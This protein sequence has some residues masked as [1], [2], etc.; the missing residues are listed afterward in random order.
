MRMYARVNWL[1]ERCHDAH[2]VRMRCME[3]RQLEETVERIEREMRRREIVS[4]N[5]RIGD[6]CDMVMLMDTYA[7]INVLVRRCWVRQ[8]KTTIQDMKDRIRGYEKYTL[9]KHLLACDV[10]RERTRLDAMVRER[11]EIDA[12]L[13]NKSMM[14]EKRLAEY[15]A[16]DRYEKKMKNVEIE[17]TIWDMQVVVQEDEKTMMEQKTRHGDTKSRLAALRSDRHEM[18]DRRAEKAVLQDKLMKAN[19]MMKTHEET[20]AVYNAYME[21]FDIKGEAIEGLIRDQ[22]QRMNVHMNKI[23]QEYVSYEVEFDINDKG[24]EYV[25]TRGNSVLTPSHLSGFE[26]FVFDI[27][28]KIS[29]NL[30]GGSYRSTFFAIDEGLDVVDKVNIERMHVLFDYMRTLYNTVFI[31]T[32]RDGIDQCIDRTIEM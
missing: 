19:E 26:Q 25:I 32:H 21:M 15:D 8:A 17:K 11:R 6:V 27:G 29:L 23:L 30:F 13:M 1:I 10:R 7:K 18:G 24:L 4:M 28:L 2:V 5:K 16:W 31:I 12:W 20:M 14:I 22:I 9:S 3:I